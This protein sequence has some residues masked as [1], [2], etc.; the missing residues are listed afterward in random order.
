MVG[1]VALISPHHTHGHP[2]PSVLFSAGGIIMI[3]LDYAD[4]VTAFSVGKLRCSLVDCSSPI[5]GHLLRGPALTLNDG[6][7]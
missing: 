1:V 3:A 5:T 2:K 4:L 6:R 7:L